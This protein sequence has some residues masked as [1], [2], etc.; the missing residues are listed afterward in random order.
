MEIALYKKDM[1]KLRKAYNGIQFREH[2]HPLEKTVQYFATV[3]YDDCLIDDFYEDIEI[4]SDEEHFNSH[5]L[6]AVDKNK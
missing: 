2:L 5:L 6:G 3:L 1:N 4:N